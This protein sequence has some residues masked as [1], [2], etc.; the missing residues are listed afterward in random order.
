ME[1]RG[2]RGWRGRERKRETEIPGG[3]GH[4]GKE[5]LEKG[6]GMLP[7]ESS[8]RSSRGRL[9]EVSGEDLNKTFINFPGVPPEGLHWL[10]GARGQVISP[11]SWSWCQPQPYSISLCCYSGPG[12]ETQWKPPFHLQRFILREWWC[13]G[14]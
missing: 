8:V 11:C 4:L 10:F 12:A 13:K 5:S 1:L 6:M 2:L 14:L 9:C 3:R 7:G